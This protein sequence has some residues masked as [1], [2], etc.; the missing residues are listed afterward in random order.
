MSTTYVEYVIKVNEVYATFVKFFKNIPLNTSILINY[1]GEVSYP[2]NGVSYHCDMIQGDSVACL[3]KMYSELVDTKVLLE[4][5][6]RLNE[7]LRL[8]KELLESKLAHIEA[9][10]DIDT[11]QQNDRSYCSNHNSADSNTNAD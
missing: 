7:E 2:I 10:C 6:K 1:V 5:Q 4:N 8:D 9:Y 11:L 3:L